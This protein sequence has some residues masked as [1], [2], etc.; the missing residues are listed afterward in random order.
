MAL[1]TL[2][3]LEKGGEVVLVIDIFPLVE[4]G[5]GRHSHRRLP[6]FWKRKGVA[7][8]K[9]IPPLLKREWGSNVPSQPLS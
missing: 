9:G 4:K 5:S 6:F 3:L 1:D 7:M 8:V 2:P